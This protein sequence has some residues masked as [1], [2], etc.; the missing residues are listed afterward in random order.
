MGS[1]VLARRRGLHT[2]PSWPEVGEEL[3]LRSEE[4]SELVPALPVVGV[5]GGRGFCG[6]NF[7]RL[8]FYFWV[9]WWFW[10][11][12]DRSWRR[13]WKWVQEEETDMRGWS[14]S[15][16]GGPVAC[17]RAHNSARE[18]RRRKSGHRVIGVITCVF[19]NVV[20]WQIKHGIFQ[21]PWWLATFPRAHAMDFGLVL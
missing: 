7:W 10:A 3:R 2:W 19:F 4:G 9:K 20:L 16:A 21:K 18:G 15:M 6:A 11:N 8:L 13:R 17:A 1:G 5:G 14:S 12:E